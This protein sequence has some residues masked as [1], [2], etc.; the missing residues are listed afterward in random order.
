MNSI[1]RPRRRGR[2]KSVN[3]QVFG[4]LLIHEAAVN[5]DGPTYWRN[6][7]YHN[8]RFLAEATSAELLRLHRQKDDQHD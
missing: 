1:R 4:W 6:T 8:R 5:I 3:F 2:V 7:P